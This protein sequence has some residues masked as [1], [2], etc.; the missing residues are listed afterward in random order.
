MGWALWYYDHA[1]FPV[2]QAVYPDREN[3]FP[4]ESGFDPAFAQP[5]LQPGSPMT[6]A[7]DDFWASADP[8]SSLFDW[9]FAD[10]PHTRV[11]LSKS[12]HEGSEPVT[13]VSHD[14]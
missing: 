9:K 4:E 3:R 14:E 5:L 8:K 7:E 6:D 12:V 1:E 10:S 2:L 11:F 13:Y